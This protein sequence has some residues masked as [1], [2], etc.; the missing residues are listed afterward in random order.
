LDYSIG[1]ARVI[2]WFQ[3]GMGD[4]QKKYHTSKKFLCMAWGS[5]GLPTVS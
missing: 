1:Q 3:T 5:R 4:V 2:S